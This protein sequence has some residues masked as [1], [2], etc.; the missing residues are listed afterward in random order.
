MS[1]GERRV[2]VLFRDDARIQHRSSER[3]EMRATPCELDEPGK[4]GRDEPRRQNAPFAHEVRDVEAGQPR[5]CCA[6]SGEVVV[7]D[8]GYDARRPEVEPFDVRECGQGLDILHEA[9]GTWRGDDGSAEQSKQ[10]GVEPSA[11]GGER[12]NQ[13]SSAWELFDREC[14]VRQG[15]E[16]ASTNECGEVVTTSTHCEFRQV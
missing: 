6:E 15:R 3:L 9:A 16:L 4:R 2:L 12:I 5:P 14:D 11:H 8:R 7:G 1:E 13:F 10:C